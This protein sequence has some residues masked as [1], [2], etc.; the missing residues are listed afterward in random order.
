M[1]AQ[2]PISTATLPSRDD[3][4]DLVSI[5]KLLWRGRWWIVG[6]TTIALSLGAVYAFWIAVP[7]YTASATVALDSREGNVIEFES[8]VSG[9]SSDISTINTEIEVMRSRDLIG[10]LVRDLNL[11]ADPEFNRALRPPTFSL[12]DW[13]ADLAGAGSERSPAIAT[14]QQILDRAINAVLAATAVTNL[15]NSLVFQVTA[16]TENAV[17]SAQ[18][19]N[20]LAEIYIRDQIEVKFDATAQATLW[21]GQRVADLGLELQVA[22][23]DLQ[24]FTAS[25]DLVTPAEVAG[26]NRQISDIRSRLA[27]T[28]AQIDTD[29]GRADML[30]DAL[31]AEDWPRLAS[32]TGDRILDRLLALPDDDSKA[33]ALS[34]RGEQLA[35]IATRSER[36]GTAQ[37][38]ALTTSLA[39]LEA[40]INAQSEG[41]VE[42]QGLERKVE[43]A[44][45][46]FEYFQN[47]L[48]ETTV[49]QGI[50]QAD[51]RLLSRAVVPGE[52]SE[53]RRPVILA[54]AAMLGLMAGAGGV[55]LR[56]VRNTGVRSANDLEALTGIVVMG[57]LPMI[58]TKSSR[59]MIEYL[60]QKPNSRLAESF[61]N[62]RT[63]VMLSNLDRPPQIIM[64]T[65]SLPNEGKTTQSLALAQNFAG[66]GKSILLIECD[67]RRRVFG[68]EL[69]FRDEIGLL[70]VL[71]GEVMLADAVQRDPQ[72]GAV[73][74]LVGDSGTSNPVDIFSSDTFRAFLTDARTV[75]DIIIIDTPP[76]LAVP[77]SRVIAQHADAILYAVKWNS[78]PRTAVR[79]GMR[80]L[81][82][83]NAR[84][85][86]LVLTQ[87]DVKRMERS[88]YGAYGQYDKGYY[89]D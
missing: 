11:T 16:R 22:Q 38:A 39:E 53:P 36:R 58:G 69:G 33:T 59:E 56:E 21:L 67:I 34:A 49:Q 6:A 87:V 28:R 13:L 20:L 30:A 43:Q 8:V 47:R 42:F 9:L 52:P 64:S 62:L 89:S 81:E 46:L 72:L 19:A 65:S 51:A 57:Q 79:E 10:K 3:E 18:I 61:R 83:V 84:I 37:I 17:K 78:T 76:V 48:R 1:T 88:G 85:S 44:R 14:D 70:S 74:V 68:S 32:L 60:S 26:L 63:S 7:V 31:A 29:V 41:L 4:V 40:Q 2:T 35:N 86:G 66:M 24:A 12:R 80:L 5:L 75:Y 77:D 23:S 73:D 27:S 54:L 82:T 50:Q 15:R 25:A 45:V 71:S 55:L